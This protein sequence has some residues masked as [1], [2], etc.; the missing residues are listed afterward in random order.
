MYYV[1]MKICYNMLLNFVIV[2]SNFIIMINQNSMYML[3]EIINSIWFYN[4]PYQPTPIRYTG[5]SCGVVVS[6][7]MIIPEQDIL[8]PVQGGGEG[9]GVNP[10]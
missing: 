9:P 10:L 3:C 7:L 2:L 8:R 1:Y 4:M 5:P 6:A